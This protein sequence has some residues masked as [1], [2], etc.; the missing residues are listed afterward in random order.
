MEPEIV[1]RPDMVKLA[2][3]QAELAS[4]RKMLECIAA[5]VVPIGPRNDD[6]SFT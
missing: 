1:D 4:M 6:G 3:I 5:S 2:A